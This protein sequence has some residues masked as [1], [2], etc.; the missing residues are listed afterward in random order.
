MKKDLVQAFYEVYGNDSKRELDSFF[1]PGRVNLIGEHI[2]YNGG[3]V[4][5]CSLDL[6]IYMLVR[7]RK[8]N[9][10][11]LTSLNM[12]SQIYINAK[13][14][15]V[16]KKKDY[17]ANYPK[18]VIKYFQNLGIDIG[19]MDILYYG[20]LPNS[21]GLSSSAALEVVTAYALNEL[22]NG[23]LTRLKIVELSQ[24]VER[25]FLGVNC[26]IMDQFA[27]GFGK[28]NSA[29]L[30]NCN[31]LEYK[32][33]PLRLGDYKI[34]ICNTNKKRGLAESKYNERRN[35]C[36]SALKDLQKRLDINYLCDLTPDQFEENKDVIQ[37]P[38]HRKRAKH[39]V[40]ENARVIDTTKELNDNNIKGF[41]QLMNESHKSLRD[42]YEV[43][44]QELDVLVDEA[45]KIDGT[46]G[47]RMT[48]A[49][50][51]GCTVNIVKESEIVRFKEVVSKE[52]EKRTDIKADIYIANV[53]EG[54][55][56][57]EQL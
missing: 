53:G 43:S 2:D 29:I 48:G 49:G 45:L 6:G 23:K 40:Y 47:A 4:F 17:W 15:I 7:K 42:L 25:E 10:I 52:Y 41:G 51:G 26:G 3:M 11:N 35:E 57:I 44:C 9:T 21:S 32:Y 38:I 5:P 13:E 22:F 31:T 34:V 39:A 24:E 19:G 28:D 12:S 50:F 33:A 1:A 54:V 36:D 37:N 14:D 8:D 18:G 56:K 46:L 16:F 27:V 55:R 30:L 20:N